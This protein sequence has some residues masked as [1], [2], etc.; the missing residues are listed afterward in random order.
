MEN[1]NNEILSALNWRYATKVFDPNKK[2]SAEDWNVI[3]ESLRLAASS[4]GLQ[5][6]KFIL[7]EN[8]DLRAQM[9]EVSW[10]QSQV[11]DSSHYLVLAYLNKIDEPYIEKFVTSIAKQRGVERE[12]LDG[13]YSVMKGALI[14]GPRSQA[15]GEWA[16]RQTYIAMGHAMLTAAL[17][18]IDTC[19][20]EGFDPQAYDKLLGLEGTDYNAIG[21]IAF[22][23]RAAEDKYQ[24]LKKVRFENNEIFETR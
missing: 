7:V 15:I 2:I 13:Y 23:Y 19:A 12:T 1:M 9:R 22:G 3:S 10:G 11:T 20:L 21:A 5:P 17:Q 8:E 4:F 18:K 24:D 14:D 6:W 16:Q